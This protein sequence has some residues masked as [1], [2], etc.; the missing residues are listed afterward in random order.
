MGR[1][2]GQI[3]HENAHIR[4]I[5][6]PVSRQAPDF[7]TTHQNCRCSFVL[8]NV[9]PT[10]CKLNGIQRTSRIKGDENSECKLSNGW[11]RRY[12]EIKL[13]LSPGTKSDGE[14]TG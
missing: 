1:S 12:R 2:A 11:S 3:K 7:R 14:V 4:L 5:F 8:G 6:H 10:E 13:L 9:T